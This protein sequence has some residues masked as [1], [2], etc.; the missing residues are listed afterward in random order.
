MFF[1]QCF[2]IHVKILSQNHVLLYYCDELCENDFI[3]VR[4]GMFLFFR[5]GKIALFC[6]PYTI[7]RTN[8]TIIK[9][10]TIRLFVYLQ[11]VN[12]K[13]TM[14]RKKEYKAKPC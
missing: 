4:N 9:R 14:K 12:I 7:I 3:S 6:Y 10:I 11:S 8:I 1:V 13:T 2:I 5:Y